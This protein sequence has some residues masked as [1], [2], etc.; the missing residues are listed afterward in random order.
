LDQRT[1]ETQAGSSPEQLHA[2][3]VR[4]LGL[5]E[6][7]LEADDALRKRENAFEDILDRYAQRGSH[8]SPER[9]QSRDRGMER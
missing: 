3:T 7:S 6:K 2:K 1:S 8:K 9:D 4:E 5:I